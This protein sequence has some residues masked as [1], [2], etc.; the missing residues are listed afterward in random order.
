MFYPTNNSK[1]KTKSKNHL[2]S[3]FRKQKVDQLIDWQHIRTLCLHERKQMWKKRGT[4]WIN[5]IKRWVISTCQI[6]MNNWLVPQWIFFRCL[7][8]SCLCIMLLSLPP[9]NNSA[10]LRSCFSF[11]LPFT[12]L[13]LFSFCPCSLSS[14]LLDFAHI[15]VQTEWKASPIPTGWWYIILTEYQC[16]ITNKD[17]HRHS[18]LSSDALLPLLFFSWIIKLSCPLPSP[19]KQGDFWEMSGWGKQWLLKTEAKL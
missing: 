16:Y 17:K 10:L 5:E 8:P 6:K 3:C 4:T 18:L 19:L 14:F 13:S 15:Y 2:L 9:S 7:Y 12:C 1:M 11:P